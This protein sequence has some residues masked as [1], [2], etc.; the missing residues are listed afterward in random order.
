MWK[1]NSNSKR[2]EIYSDLL[3]PPPPHTH[4]PLVC[5]SPCCHFTMYAACLG[6]ARN[7][8]ERQVFALHSR[9][10]APQD[11]LSKQFCAPSSESR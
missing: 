8:K 5:H 6:L 10:K 3:K 2:F 9:N 4:L 1:G 11:L 7:P